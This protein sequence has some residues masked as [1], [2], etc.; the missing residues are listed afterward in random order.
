MAWAV[1]KEVQT[2]GE[3]ETGGEVPNS[4]TTKAAG[5]VGYQHESAAPTSQEK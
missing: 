4:K 1:E 5:A 3:R 2:S